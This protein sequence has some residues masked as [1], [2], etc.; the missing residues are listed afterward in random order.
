MEQ[1]KKKNIVTAVIDHISSCMAPVIPIL[2]AGGL[3]KLLVIILTMTGAL[4]EG[5]HTELVLSIIGD[6][7]LYFLPFFLAYTASVH[8]HV[9]TVLAI[10]AVGAM[11][12]PAFVELVSSAGKLSFAGIPLVKATYA[13][14][15]IPIIL[16]IAAMIHVEKLVH[17][18]MPKVLD[19]ILSPLVI[20]LLSSLLGILLIGPIGTLI[21][22]FLSGIMVWLQAHA[23]VAAWALFA[24]L[25]PLF[26]ITGTHWVFVAVALSQLG[27][28]GMEDGVMVGF[29]ILTL[30][31]AG[32]CLAA[33]FRAKTSALK[34]LALSC[35]VTVFLT[36]VTEP[37]IYGVSLPYR[38]PL[39]TSM[40]GASIA[41]AYQ[42]LVTI[43]CYVYAFPGMPSFLMFADSGEP[44]NLMKAMI[45]AAIS[46]AASFLL[47]L[48][49][50]GRF[51]GDSQTEEAVHA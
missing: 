26:V 48:V 39:I 5:S 13:Y 27:T 8:F 31:Q 38:R 18:L 24:G 36:G 21:G 41:G 15:T 47:T 12:S 45:A 25:S 51:D 49:F 33:F 23:P 1:N 9:N 50:G 29:F 6:A 7:P 10:G 19:D 37:P 32:T 30:S 34:K 43:H 28:F 40:I 44:D 4:L 20:L 22:N 2:V 46:F 42:G 11:M 14:S 16:L 3:I 35:A 17:K